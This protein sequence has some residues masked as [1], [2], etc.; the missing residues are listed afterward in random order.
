[1]PPPPPSSHSSPTRTRST[2][3]ASM[4]STNATIN[5]SITRQQQHHH[6]VNNRSMNQSPSRHQMTHA[7]NNSVSATAG[8]IH[9]PPQARQQQS[10]PSPRKRNHRR[11]ASQP[12]SAAGLDDG[13]VHATPTSSLPFDTTTSFVDLSIQPP[14]Q[15]S[16][17]S[18]TDNKINNNIGS[19]AASSSPLKPPK[20]TKGRNSSR[21]SSPPLEPMTHHHTTV[22]TDS[23]AFDALTS[24]GDDE[25]D[26]PAIDQLAISNKAKEA[27]TWQQQSLSRS[28]SGTKR[29]RNMNSN[30]IINNNNSNN[31]NR[32]KNKASAPPQLSS[33]PLPKDTRSSRRAN[34]QA[35]LAAVAS[36]FESSSSAPPVSSALTWQQELLQQSDSAAHTGSARFSSTVSPHKGNI[37]VS[38]Q[39]RQQQKDNETF[40]LGPLDFATN[41]IAAHT[42]PNKRV[43]QR[44]QP[45]GTRQT[46]AGSIS[47]PSKPIEE[48]YAGPTFHNSP[49]ASSLPT[50]SFMLRKNKALD[51]GAS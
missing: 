48:R 35:G 29:S 38:K 32:G 18:T 10:S 14:P 17:P 36:D 15:T 28:N 39:R 21:Q 1:M 13:D 31:N 44:Q 22:G 5:K 8:L 16:K 4:T 46:T 3:P 20:R 50:P 11:P 24:S 27:L 37:P 6:H 34:K 49:L 30:N 33:S 41:N 7:G 25:W 9:L 42:S 47:T 51:L 26:M 12:Q 43:T 40:G 2:T 19:K 23:I 45:R